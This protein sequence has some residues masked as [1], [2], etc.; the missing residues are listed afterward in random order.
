MRQAGG[1]DMKKTFLKSKKPIFTVMTQ[2]K[3]PQRI[4]ELID[5]ST[6]FGAEAFGMQF[7]RLKPEYKN[8]E[9]YKELFSYSDKPVYATNYRGDENEGK[10]DETLAEEL[11]ELSKCGA[12]LCDVIGDLFDKQPDELAKSEE[13]IAK[14][15]KLIDELHK[16]GSEVLMSSH[17]L[18]FTPAKR[19]LEVALE[20]QRR[21]AD[22][23]K[24]VTGAET[25][26]E[27]LENLKIVNMLKN[28]LK[29]PF[30]FLSSGK[31]EI[32]R[33]IGGELGSC[34]YLCVYEQDELSTREQPLLKELKAIREIK[35]NIGGVHNEK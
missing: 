24:I 5:K 12:A 9:T 11:L 25:M 19:V 2:A 32:L 31:C 35:E 33:R 28:E 18:K 13:A 20:H 1:A 10:S 6:P 16:N 30:L 4:K 21:G 3:D 26:E 27:Q 8:C 7:E 29:I 17:I 15:K 22:I 34:M 23:C 14:Q